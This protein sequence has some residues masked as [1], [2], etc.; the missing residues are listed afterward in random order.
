MKQNEHRG[1]LLFF[2][3]SLEMVE[4]KFEEIMRRKDIDVEFGDRITDGDCVCLS[5]S[6][7]SCY[8][9]PKNIFNTPHWYYSSL[10]FEGKYPPYDSDRK[11]RVVIEIVV[12][13][14]RPSLSSMVAEIDERIKRRDG[15]EEELKE[16]ACVL[17]S[18]H[19]C[20]C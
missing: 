12:G 16:M 17:S 19:R 20:S 7:R 2:I 4:R 14:C 5:S 3:S 8:L 18:A 13:K 11:G 10:R 6:L 9:F 15:T 1:E